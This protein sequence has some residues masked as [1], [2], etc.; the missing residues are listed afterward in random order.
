MPVP[1][2]ITVPIFIMSVWREPERTSPDE[3]GPTEPWLSL[4]LAFFASQEPPGLGLGLFHRLTDIALAES[5]QQRVG[6]DARIM[7]VAPCELERVAA[8]RLDI[9]HHDEQR[10]IFALQTALPRPFVH[11]GRAGTVL[12]EVANRVDTPVAVA[13]L[14]SQHSF[15]K[16]LHIQRLQRH[17]GHRVTCQDLP[18]QAPAMPDL[19]ELPSTSSGPELV[20]SRAEPVPS[21]ADDKKS[22]GGSRLPATTAT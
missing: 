15:V 3:R 6:V 20:G 13:P 21:N 18:E 14:N 1:I 8:D 22:N 4:F 19:G 5:P 9:L 2:I 7:A 16:P 12:S 11:A 17:G 10:H